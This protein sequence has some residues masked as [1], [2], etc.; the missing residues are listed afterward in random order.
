MISRLLCASLLALAL[1]SPAGAKALIEM[2]WDEANPAFMAKHMAQIE[3]QPFDGLVYVVGG[4]RGGTSG[5]TELTIAGTNFSNRW[6]TET[7]CPRET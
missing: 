2:G 1:A 7:P 5:G 4:A 6:S 3:A